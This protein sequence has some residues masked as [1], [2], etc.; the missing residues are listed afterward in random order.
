M[1]PV[2]NLCWLVKEEVGYEGQ[3]LGKPNT[4]ECPGLRNKE[5]GVVP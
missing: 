1:L 2:S 3:D 4:L 5:S